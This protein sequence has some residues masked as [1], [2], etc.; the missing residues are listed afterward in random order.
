MGKSMMRPGFR[1]HPTDVELV[2]YYLKNKLLGID[3]DP[4]FIAEVNINNFSPCDLPAKSILT[5]DLEWYFFCPT[6]K[7]YKSGH[8]K[9]R[10]TETGYWKGTGIDREV[11]NKGRIVAKKKTLIFHEGHSPNGKRT[12]WVMHEFRMQDEN[13][14]N[15]GVAQEAYI[16]CRVFKKSG[17]GPK[18]G[19]QYGAPFEEKDWDDDDDERS[20][21][22]STMMVGV[23]VNPDNVSGSS[24]KNITSSEPGPSTV[25]H[26]TKM[27]DPN[28]ST[29][30]ITSWENERLTDVTVN[31]D[32][33]LTHGGV[34]SLQNNNTQE[35]ED[36]KGKKVMIVPVNEN[37]LTFEDLVAHSNNDLSQDDFNMFTID[38]FADDDDNFDAFFTV[39]DFC[40]FQEE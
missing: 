33:M 34:V 14:D 1:F 30:T 9:D 38:G 10:A 17:L 18:N 20:T 7:K 3:L 25:T 27:L 4:E 13:L 23:L 19:A 40:K 8:R 37:D 5:G 15:Q 29:S 6:S 11:K 28:A 31:D 22:T 24:M 35:V 12:D 36:H 21:V 32:V 2:M 39:D 16:I 26:S